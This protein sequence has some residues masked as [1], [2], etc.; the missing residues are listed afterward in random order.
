[1]DDATPIDLEYVTEPPPLPDRP[2]DGHKGTFGRV[3]VVGG[4]DAM[5]GAPVLAGTAALRMGSGLV[6]LALPRAMVPFA[7]SITPELTSL[8]LGKRPNRTTLAA[9]AEKAD[10]VVVGPGLGTGR[11]ARQRLWRLLEI[12]KP[13]VIDADALNLIAASGS[14]PATVALKA[15]LTPHPGEMA[16]LLPLVEPVAEGEAAPRVPSDEE[17]RVRVAVAAA[18][19]FR[20]VVLLK[21]RR[22]VVTDGRRVYVNATGD[23]SLA[24]GGTGDVLAGIIGSLIGQ[25]MDAFDAACRGAHLHG[26]AGEIAGRKLGPRSVLARDVIDA[27]SEACRT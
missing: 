15:V 5:L 12:D 1:M 27:I 26:H 14:W 20:Q 13:A 4:S 16:R 19:A 10:V 2:V 9:A 22:T 8:P 25:G 3:L 21:G 24:K 11:L 17:G 18:R 23:S 6:Q 7:L